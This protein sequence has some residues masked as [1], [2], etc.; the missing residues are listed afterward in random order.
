MGRSLGQEGMRTLGPCIAPRR[1]ALPD[2][3]PCSRQLQ[4]TVSDAQRKTARDES[5]RRCCV[6]G[7]G[8]GGT[9]ATVQSVQSSIRRCRKELG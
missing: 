7:G 4:S 6:G 2:A 1:C 8:G 9:P 5:M 3:V